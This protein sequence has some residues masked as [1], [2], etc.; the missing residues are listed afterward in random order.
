MA[1]KIPSYIQDTTDFLLKIRNYKST[2]VNNTI[3]ATLDVNALY[4]N[5]NQEEGVH[6]CHEY[7]ERRSEK[8]V[9]SKVLCKLILF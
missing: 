4:P 7:L 8:S 2:D 3:L 1:Q 9:S 5:I 6:A